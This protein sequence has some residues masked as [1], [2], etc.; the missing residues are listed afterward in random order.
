MVDSCPLCGRFTEEE[1][2]NWLS[3]IPTDPAEIQNQI[4]NLERKHVGLRENEESLLKLAENRE[5]MCPMCKELM[6]GIEDESNKKEL[7]DRINRQ[8][9][10]LEDELD[11][12]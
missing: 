10:D 1:Q 11:K 9:L 6:E 8:I 7:E 4:L 3:R 2:E 12:L 5:K